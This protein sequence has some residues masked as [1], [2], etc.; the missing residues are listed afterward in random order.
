M[1]KKQG[2]IELCMRYYHLMLTAVAILV[3]LGGYAL[4][5]MPKQEFPETTIR[6]GLIVAVYPGA[7][8]E[9]VEEQVAKPLEEFVFTYPEVKKHK[10]TSTSSD[11]M[12]IMQVELNDDVHNKDEVWSKIKHGLGTLKPRLP[13]GVLALQAMDDFGDTSALL[14]AIESEDK[15]YR[16][17][18]NY[19]TDL[20]G[21]LRAIESASNLRRYELQKEQISIYLDDDRIV[22]YGLNVNQLRLKLFAEG[23]TTGGAHIESDLVLSIIIVVAVMLLLF[24]LRSAIV[25]AISIPVAIAITLAI[26]FFTGIPLNTVTLAALIVVLGMIVDNS[27]IVIDAYQEYL[28]KGYSRWHATIKS[29]KDYFAPILLATACICIIFFPPFVG[30]ERY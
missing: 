24:S 18:E 25:A 6:Q 13:L 22:A 19:L 29:A 27:I 21:W 2:F 11:D 12:L 16:E 8:P 9:E 30:Y 17:L 20:E 26:M 10:T 28:D 14:I 7:T 5:V 1:N 4:L 15:T 3:A 23:L